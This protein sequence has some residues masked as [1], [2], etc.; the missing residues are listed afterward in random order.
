[1]VL[2]WSISSAGRYSD[3]HQRGHQR[4]EGAVEATTPAGLAV[5]A[6]RASEAW[7]PA[8]LAIKM[9]G[10]ISIPLMLFALGVRDQRARATSAIRL[11]GDRR[12]GAAAGIDWRCSA[13]L[14]APVPL[15]AQERALLIVFGALLPA[16][17]NYMFA[18]RYHQEP[19]KVARWC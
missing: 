11:G 2:N 17:L 6:S 18:E 10:D 7:P 19:E 9:F 8:M 15:P 5:W 14:L 1:M 16:A 4:P 3:H 13:A 12:R